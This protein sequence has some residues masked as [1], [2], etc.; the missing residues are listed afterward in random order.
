MSWA[1]GSK[2]HTLEEGVDI[3]LPPLTASDTV[4]RPLHAWFRCAGRRQPGIQAARELGW[5]TVCATHVVCMDGPQH[6]PTYAADQQQQQRTSRRSSSSHMLQP[7]HSADTV[8]LAHRFTC[9][10][11]EP[12][13]ASFEV[14]SA[15][16]PPVSWGVS[17]VDYPSDDGKAADLSMARCGQKVYLEVEVLDAHSNRWGSLQALACAIVCCCGAVEDAHR[18]MMQVLSVPAVCQCVLLDHAPP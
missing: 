10:G 14:H 8:L 18:R 12:L 11:L 15:P 2:K 1:K 7:M 9:P 3:P 17:R 16:G 6:Q 4:G 5:A 13:E